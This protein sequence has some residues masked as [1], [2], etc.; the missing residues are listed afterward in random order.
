MQSEL[1]AVSCVHF[2]VVM[3]PMQ[4]LGGAL[5]PTGATDVSGL[6]APGSTEAHVAQPW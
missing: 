4:Y 1:T 6:A 3:R 2:T 5:Q